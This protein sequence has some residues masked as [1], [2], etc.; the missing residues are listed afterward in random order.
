M[1]CQP[2]LKGDSIAAIELDALNNNS[3]LDNCF[4]GLKSIHVVNKFGD[5]HWEI[6]NIEEMGVPLDHHSNSRRGQK[7]LCIVLWRTSLKL[8]F[9]DA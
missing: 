4:L 5:E 9:L 8:L 7:K 3:T 1:E 2:H 6:Y